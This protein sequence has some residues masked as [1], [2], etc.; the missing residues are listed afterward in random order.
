MGSGS[1][2]AGN[3][4]LPSINGSTQA[5]ATNNV[6]FQRPTIGSYLGA[7]IIQD[8]QYLRQE[9]IEI[10]S[11]LSTIQ[12]ELGRIATT[13]VRGNESTVRAQIEQYKTDVQHLLA[14]RKSITEALEANQKSIT[15]SYQSAANLLQITR[16]TNGAVA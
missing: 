9:L 1:I 7:P 13:G 6:S 4:F 10:N 15:Q 2:G 12:A 8:P 14:R 11:Q 5:S 3:S 16:P